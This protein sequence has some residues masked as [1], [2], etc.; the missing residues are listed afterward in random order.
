M[1]EKG[2]T[3]AEHEPKLA[4]WNGTREGISAED[5]ARLA[6][7]DSP[8]TIDAD[9]LRATLRELWPSLA[10]AA[11]LR[12]ETNHADF[13]PYSVPPGILYVSGTGATS[14][15]GVD[16]VAASTSALHA[17][18]EALRAKGYRIERVP[19]GPFWKNRVRVADG[20]RSS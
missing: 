8:S 14:R 11:G 5:M 13:Y 7:V 1:E 4:Y 17:L 3:C 6:A 2:C 12:V 16:A 18:G 10:V 15:D 9:A 19:E 20:P